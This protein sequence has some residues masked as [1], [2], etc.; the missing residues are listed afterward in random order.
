MAA[1]DQELQALDARID[2]LRQSQ[3]MLGNY[4]ADMRRHSAAP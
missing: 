3:E 2:R 1:M 4:Y